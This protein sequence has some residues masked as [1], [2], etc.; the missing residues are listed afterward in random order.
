MSDII[1]AT[2]NA[3]LEA[4]KA[5][6]TWNLRL[7]PLS[8]KL[9]R[10]A[11]TPE[12]DAYRQRVEPLFHEADDTLRAKGIPSALERTSTGMVLTI[13]AERYSVREFSHLM[14]RFEYTYDEL[15]FVSA[16]V[17]IGGGWGAKHDVEP[18]RMDN[19][20]A[21]FLRDALLARSDD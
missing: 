6:P 8:G 13:D 11:P 20:L 2:I 19:A 10:L 5:K 3:A 17:R 21:H 15:G 18:D 7:T 1:K 4:K 12:S 9:L 14:S 16:Y